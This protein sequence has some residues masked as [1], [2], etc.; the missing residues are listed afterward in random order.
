MIFDGEF[1]TDSGDSGLLFDG[2]LLMEIATI[3]YFGHSEFVRIS[4]FP[5]I[6]IGLNRV[7]H[8]G[9]DWTKYGRGQ[10]SVEM[11]TAKPWV[12]LLVEFLIIGY[13]IF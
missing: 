6:L 12:K 3:L 7:S 4:P 13:L 8:V 2:A 11:G 1:R 10:W 5:A 9:H